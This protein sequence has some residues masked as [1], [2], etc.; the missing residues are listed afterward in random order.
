[1]NVIDAYILKCVDKI[2]INVV[3]GEKYKVEKKYYDQR[4]AGQMSSTFGCNKCQQC[5]HFYEEQIEYHY[6]H[7]CEMEYDCFK[8]I[9]KMKET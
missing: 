5:V 3:C 8:P 9:D 7:V 4:L 6:C 1:M 2:F